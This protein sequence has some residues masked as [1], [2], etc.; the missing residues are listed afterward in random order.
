MMARGVKGV[1]G[2]QTS[3]RTTTSNTVTRHSVL[4]LGDNFVSACTRAF[5]SMATRTNERRQSKA[6]LGRRRKK[7]ERAKLSRQRNS[8]LK[9]TTKSEWQLRHRLERQRRDLLLR[10]CD[11]ARLQHKATGLQPRSL[12]SISEASR[13]SL[14]RPHPSSPRLSTSVILV[15]VDSSPYH[16]L[17]LM[18]PQKAAGE[19]AFSTS[20][21]MPTDRRG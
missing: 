21:R 6:I 9:I 7:E 16:R 4:E 5:S 3:I 18:H 12:A 15:T 8:R 10:R 20:T 17:R 13:L 14:L 19:V 1:P 11:P 2:T